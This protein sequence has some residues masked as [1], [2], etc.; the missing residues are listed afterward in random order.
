MTKLD[1]IKTFLDK[2]KHLPE[3]RSTAWKA[4][5][6]RQLTGGSEAHYIVNLKKTNMNSFVNNFL[7]HKIID[8]T[9][10]FIFP[11]VFGNIFENEIKNLT[12][13]N[14]KTEIFHKWFNWQL[15]FRHRV[16]IATRL[17]KY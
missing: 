4:S 14:F 8:K 7:Y 5:R 15:T 16:A 12:E 17:R 6:R 2:Y 13:Y 9:N 3:Q 1:K 11:C 10:Y